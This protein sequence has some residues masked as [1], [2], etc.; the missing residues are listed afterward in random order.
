M[1]KRRVL[2]IGATGYIVSHF[3]DAFRNRYDLRLIDSRPSNRNGESVEGVE[4]VDLLETEMDELLTYFEGI[5]TVV[6]SAYVRPPAQADMRSEYAYERQNVDL[7]Y[8]ILQ[9]SLEAGVRR[10]VAMST[11]QA[12]KWYERPYFA[13]KRDRVT[14]YE[15][16]RAERFYG[17][18]K[19]AFESLGFVYASGTYGRKLENIHIRIVAPREIESQRYDKLP[20]HRYLRDIT[21]Y[22]SPRDLE[23]LVHKCIETPDI[24][25]EHG[26]PFHIFY[27]VSNNART[28]WSITNARQV[29]GYEPKDDA[30]IR[31]ADDIREIVH[32][33]ESHES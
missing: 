15:Y 24:D 8:R 13:G 27:G 25:D 10:V 7:A 4:I 16:P 3:L 1:S 22:L 26:V 5:D 33:R 6:H 17:W 19:A 12:A 21:G 14:P 28:F 9:L 20:L 23:Q 18:A 29:V 11:N 32:R 2:I 31:F 30:E